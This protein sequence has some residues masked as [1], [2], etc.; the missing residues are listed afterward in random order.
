MRIE[1]LAWRRVKSALERP[2]F[3]TGKSAKEEQ[4]GERRAR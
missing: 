4:K 2:G 3:R 1:R